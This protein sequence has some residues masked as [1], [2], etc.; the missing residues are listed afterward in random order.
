LWKKLK[1][2]GADWKPTVN[3]DIWTIVRSVNVH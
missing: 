3:F 2:S 1:V